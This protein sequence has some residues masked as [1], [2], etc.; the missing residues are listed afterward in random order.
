MA[1]VDPNRM[2]FFE[3]LEELRGRIIKSLV[4]WVL[5]FGICFGYHEEVFRI[6]AEPLVALSQGPYVFAA[7]DI[8]EPFFVHIKAC[9][10]VSLILASGIFFYHFWRFVSPGLTRSERRFAIPFLT[11]MALLFLV[12]CA[13][14]FFYAFPIA[15]EFLMSWNENGLSAY[16]RSYYISLLFSFV[17]GMGVCFELPMVVFLLSHLGIVT[18][19]FL[20]KNFKYAV[21]IV[22]AIAAVVT[23]TTD[24]VMQTMLSIPMLVLY[25]A[26]VGAAWL[27]GRRKDRNAES[28]GDDHELE[29]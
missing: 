24:V 29:R 20:L 2:S 26:G 13:F 11:F 25:L 4:L 3:H 5:C 7:V 19:R 1:K 27:V 28:T 10:W 16:T 14:S 6:L 23:P 12:G 21:V 17:I 15:L 9:F 22:F 18:P 8:K